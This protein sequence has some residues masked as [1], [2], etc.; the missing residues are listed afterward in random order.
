MHLFEKRDKFTSRGIVI[1]ILF[2]ALI[3]G[4][5]VSMLGQI[6]E[7]SVGEQT[8]LLEDALYRAA[9]T[10]YAIE[11]R[12]PPSLKYITDNFLVVI[13]EEKYIVSYSGFASNV[14][15]NIRVFVEGAEGE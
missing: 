10:C 11:G 9:V 5:F 12:Y 6:E 7:K 4:L 2:F 13:D 1:S 8:K 14:M 3:I 15:P